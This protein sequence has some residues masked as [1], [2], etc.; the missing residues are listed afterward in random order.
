MIFAKKITRQKLLKMYENVQKTY[1]KISEDIYDMDKKKLEK[2]KALN[3]NN[4][5][6]EK[7][8]V[9]HINKIYNEKMK[10]NFK[11]KFN[12]NNNK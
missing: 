1:G 11:Y 8:F 7:N 3:N 12:M 6:D 9:E 4:Q 10:S 2:F 5:E